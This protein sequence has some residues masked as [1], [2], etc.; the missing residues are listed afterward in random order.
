MRLVAM[1]TGEY[2]TQT[3][4]KAGLP[5]EVGGSKHN[6]IE[7]PIA[8]LLVIENDDDGVSVCRYTAIGEF[9]GDTWHATLTEARDQVDFEYSGA[10]IDWVSVPDDVEYALSFA[11]SRAS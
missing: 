10:L 5:P 2:S 9:A 7:L 8:S 11:L 1:L 6:Q 4:H 3:Q